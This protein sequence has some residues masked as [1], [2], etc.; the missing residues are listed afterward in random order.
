MAK[1][2]SGRYIAKVNGDN[3]AA[4][5][6]HENSQDSLSNLLESAPVAIRWVGADGTIIWANKTE[7]ELL[8]YSREEY[9]GHHIAEFHAEKPVINDILMR[10]TN[11]E[12]LNHYSA[13]LRCKDGS[14]RNVRINSNG[15]WED[16]KFIHTQCFTIDVT[17]QTESETALRDTEDRLNLALQAGGLGAWEWDIE[18]GRVNWSK[19]LEEI[20]GLVPA[21][22]G[23]TF[24][25]YQRDI[26]PDDRQAVLD[27]ISHSLET[28]THELD[29][30]IILPS[31]E[32]RWLSAQGTVVRDESGKPLRM[33][34]VCHDI[35]EDKISDLQ[36]EL[37]L[38]QLQTIYYLNEAIN[39]VHTLEEI[40]DLAVDGI[41]RSLHVDRASLLL[42]D[43]DGIM[44]LKSW[45]GLSDSYRAAT[46]GHWPWTRDTIDPQPVLV[47]D[48]RNEPSLAGLLDV[49]EAE[50]IRALAFVPLLSRGRLMGKFMLYSNPPH[51]FSEDEVQVAQTLAGNIAFAIERK[52]AEEALRE[53]E[54]NYRTIFENAV[55]GISQTTPD[56]RFLAANDALAHILGFE[57]AY[58]LT[59]GISNIG[60]QLYV[61]P[62]ER[63]RYVNELRDKGAV[64]NFEAALYRKDGAVIWISVSSR[65]LRDAND[66]V[67]LIEGIIQDVT[68]RKEAE[69]ALR[70]SEAKLAVELADTRQL[71]N[72]SG[73]LIHEDNIDALYE[74]ILDAAIALMRSDMG[75]MQIL[76]EGQDALRMLAWRGFGPEFGK[77]F[78]LVRPNTKTSCSV[79]RRAGHRVIV[80][81]VETCDFIVGTP[82]LEDH[83]KTGIQAVQS[84]PLVS[85]SGKLLGMIS[86]HWRQPHQPSERDLRLLDVLARQAADLF[87]RRKA[88]EALRDSEQ[89]LSAIFDQTS[90][91]IAQTDLTGRFVFVNQ[92]YCEIVGRP[93]S[94][95]LGMR[96]QDI[97]HPDDLPRNLEL[98]T[99]LVTDGTGFSIE[100]RYVRPDGS[101][102]WVNNSVTAIKDLNGNP[103]AAV[104]FAIDETER[105]RME[106]SL[107]ENE[108]KYR[109][110]F[111]NALS[112]ILMVEQPTR[113]IRDANQAM[114]DMLGFERAELIGQ[115]TNALLASGSAEII[116]VEREELERTGYWSGQF[117]LLKNDGTPIDIEWQI[118]THGLPGI[119][120]SIGNDIT[121]R[122]RAEEALLKAEEQYRGIFENAI[123]GIF[124]STPEGKFIRA[125]PALAHILGYDSPEELI[126]SVTSIGEQTHVNP[127]RRKDFAAELQ[128]KGFVSYFDAPVYRKEGTVIW[129]SLTARALR[130]TDEGT[131]Y[132]FEGIVED[133]THRKYLEEQATSLLSQMQAEKERVENIIATVPGMVWE[134]RDRI[135]EA[136]HRNVFVSDYVEQMFGYTAEEWLQI[137]NFLETVIHPDDREQMIR[138]TAAAIKNGSGITQAR[139]YRKDGTLF[140]AQAHMIVVYDASG[141]P[142]GLRGVT[143]DISERMQLEDEMKRLFVQ[144]EQERDRLD[145]II[146]TIPGMVGENPGM[147]GDP[148]RPPGYVSDYVQT[149]LGFSPEEWT[150]DPNLAWRLIHP[151]DKERF[152]QAFQEIQNVGKGTLEV[153]LQR[154]DGEY[155]WVET[156]VVAIRDAVGN[157]SGFRGV[158]MDISER[159]QREEEKAQLLDQVQSEKERVENIIAT[160]PGMVWEVRRNT[161]GRI[162]LTYISDYVEQ[163]SGYSAEEVQEYG[164]SDRFI[165]PDD[166]PQMLAETKQAL[167]QDSGYI[168]SFRIVRK[169]GKTTWIDARTVS[170]RDQANNI[171]GLRGVS[172]DVTEL[173]QA[174]EEREELFAL[175]QAARVE[176]EK[177]TKVMGSVQRVTE[178]ALTH[179]ALDELLDEL[180][181]RL[182]E[183]LDADIATILLLTED[184]QGISLHAYSGVAGDI[185]ED[186]YVPL[187]KGV[188]GRVAQNRELMI[189]N[190]ASSIEIISVPT[191]IR[192]KI[193]ALM[194]APLIVEG[195]LIGVVTVGA[196]ETHEFTLDNAHLLQLVADR[197]ALAIDRSR[198][199]ESEQV[200]REEAELAQ[201]ELQ[202][203]NEQKD[204]FL[205]LVSHELRTPITSIYGGVR[206]L[207]SRG[208]RLDDEARADVLADI[209]LETERLHRLVEDLLVLARLEL[210]Q[211][212]EK[213]PVLLQRTLDKIVAN[214]HQRRPNREVR[215]LTEPD[216]APVQAVPLYVEQILRNLL[217]NADKYSDIQEPVEITAKSNGDSEILISV[218]DRGVGLEPG[219]AARVFDRFYR[220]SRT[221]KKAQGIGI[222]LTVC[223][224]LVE[225][226]S[227]RI[228]AQPRDEKG[229][230]VSFTLPVYKEEA[231]DA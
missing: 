61:N 95:L 4:V 149:L 130:D 94:D 135:G 88:E 147:P 109:A 128:D 173:R 170:V 102:V 136:N 98:F 38:T 144:V 16:G 42:F 177:A 34:G 110:V 64:T 210:G 124:Q 181:L 33:L 119:A 47:P 118:T 99:H 114:C 155:L 226:Q 72:V 48:V 184:T 125:N 10:L 67:Y 222:G 122:K 70:D 211:E 40:Y 182:R 57:S 25:D 196:T 145:G 133:I 105:R 9:I 100:K 166:L 207:R 90:A 225:A 139:Y 92:R 162:T 28:G 165:H 121:E 215:L 77:I 175:E 224:R 186:V 169:D 161:E 195:R 43:E 152:Q 44:Q 156:S 103:Q 62:E 106:T 7:M 65:A 160:V 14:V 78:E 31:G 24:E 68:E 101:C 189:V 164:L 45:S 201:A 2:T 26:H 63:V 53:S 15:Y 158:T 3:V 81:D 32:V 11:R 141:Q 204:E 5:L 203:A 190:D 154:K 116:T 218:L 59:I 200:A 79:A 194:G 91:G 174:E 35:T 134:S 216:L 58:E 137:P 198:L 168:S 20:H 142:T 138:D 140:W 113:I 123:F 150:S 115:T 157:V 112:G 146:S 126:D 82:S 22:F 229:L 148:D 191:S 76:D 69:E 97:T 73:Q 39:R 96:M 199:Y 167:N 193:R 36:R 217:S 187:G 87:E 129:I 51:T 108:E 127:Q 30:R 185:S 223:K 41:I 197:V 151:D 74:Q 46:T 176:A 84:T 83:R 49:I 8:G 220:S 214:Y 75:S 86:T 208:A 178:T 13:K 1:P 56:G 188:A 209:E 143:V 171:I 50:G 132:G 12:A 66:E 19:K 227:G 21:S 89:R 172:M 111:E 212:V 131:T 23:G 107:I 29:Y 104:A 85:R 163:L 17:D 202:K 183:V 219:E 159:K 52:R 230:N 60:H 205:G 179:L 120:I 117:P 228:W 180:L 18:T 27:T 206:V 93:M 37:R 80:P 54:E 221:A 231:D 153:R 55:F 213:E 71:Q 6:N 192:D